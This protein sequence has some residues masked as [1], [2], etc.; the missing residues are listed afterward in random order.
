MTSCPPVN[1]DLLLSSSLQPDLKVSKG[2][3]PPAHLST[4]FNLDCSHHS[5]KILSRT[6][7]GSHFTSPPGTIK[8]S[9]SNNSSFN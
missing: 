1:T 9:F 7:N 4:H 5:T 3:S 8:P 2:F 6:T